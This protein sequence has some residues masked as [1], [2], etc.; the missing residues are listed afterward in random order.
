MSKIIKIPLLDSFCKHLS[1]SDI[2]LILKMAKR[3]SLC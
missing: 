2:F 3:W 1:I